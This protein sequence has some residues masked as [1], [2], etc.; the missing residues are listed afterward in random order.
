MRISL[1]I[2]LSEM[3]R[4]SGLCGQGRATSLIQVG[5]VGSGSRVAE[6]EHPSSP[7]AFTPE[8]ST[9]AAETEQSQGL[10]P[11]P[12]TAGAAVPACGQESTSQL[13]QEAKAS[14][15][16]GLQLLRQGPPIPGCGQSALLSLAVQGAAH[17]ETP[18]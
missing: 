18:S 17:P 4:S 1:C 8:P 12:R 14:C 15:S 11:V 9:T 6:A 10:Q 2:Y 16:S 7:T 13:R 3:Q 5:A